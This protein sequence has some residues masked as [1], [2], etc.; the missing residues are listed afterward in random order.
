PA[1]GSD[2]QAAL[3]LLIE[4][5]PRAARE[6]LRRADLDPSDQPGERLELLSVIEY[7]EGKYA[8]AI[9]TRQ[10]AIA[11]ARS[12][13]Q[14]AA[15]LCYET[16]QIHRELGDVESARAMLREALELDPELP[17]QPLFLEWLRRGKK[18]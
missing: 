11:A 14:H 17:F 7:V 12:E 5:R 3:R 8:D 15:R 1:S 6:L 13:P 2:A 4:G 16:S 18:L 10:Q 9:R